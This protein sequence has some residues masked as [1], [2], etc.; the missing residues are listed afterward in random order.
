MKED[1]TFS[2]LSL[3][4]GVLLMMTGHAGAGLVLFGI[5]WITYK[6]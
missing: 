2:A 1:N 4:C 3:V 6:G 5:A